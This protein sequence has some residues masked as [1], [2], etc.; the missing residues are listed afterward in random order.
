MKAHTRHQ[1]TIALY[2]PDVAHRNANEKP[3]IAAGDT[4]LNF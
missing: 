2:A 4:G 3:R 1:A